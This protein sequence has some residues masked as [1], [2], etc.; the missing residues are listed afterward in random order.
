MKEVHGRQRI[1]DLTAL[2][3]K[4]LHGYLL[5]AL[6]V[7]LAVP[8]Y[9]SLTPFLLRKL[10]SD[11]YGLWVIGSIPLA[12]LN[13]S[14]FGLKNSLV[15]RAAR[16][17]D[18]EDVAGYF[19]AVFFF[20]L[21]IGLALVIALVSWGEGLV[22]DIFNIPSRYRHEGYL[23]VLLSTIGFGIRFL[24]TPYQALLESKQEFAVINLISLLWLIAN[25]VLSIIVL[26]ISPDL[27]T[28]VST[29]VALNAV[30][31]FLYAYFC[32]KSTKAARIR[33]RSIRRSHVR[34]L[35][36]Y[37]LG[38]Y[39][40]SLAILLREPMYKTLITRE[41]GLPATASFEI[42][43]RLCCQLMSFIT[44]PAYGIFA[45]AATLAGRDAE[46]TD[47]L[48]TIQ[49]AI[50]TLTVPMAL[51]FMIFGKL[52]IGLWLGAG[53]ES[54]VMLVPWF[55]LSFALYYLSEASAKAIEGLGHARASAIVQIAGVV[56]QL[57]VFFLLKDLGLIAASISLLAGF[58]LVSLS[59]GYVYARSV[60]EPRLFTGKT[61]L[62]C[63]VPAIGYVAAIVSL[64]DRNNLPLFLL[65]LVL[66][67]EFARIAGV[68]DYRQVVSR[69]VA[70]FVRKSVLRT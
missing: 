3:Q 30:V 25:Y 22:A 18:E 1:M 65:F 61:L 57:G 14:D 62:L 12:I 58:L 10:G 35:A 55:V 33:V 36:G 11:Y 38:I 21:V 45:T 13:I 26:S 15:Y 60:K 50:L 66:H 51:F 6:R 69:L 31:F 56:L 34:A 39:A 42:T 29:G 5:G 68:I 2:K 67:L 19:N 53:H 37:G 49:G 47:I 54:V 32:N 44:L 7:I 59:Y 43:Y 4:L 9:I 70:T 8:I 52:F 23:V 41:Y 28:L 16:A 64:N 48:R 40:A 17:V 20:F 63:L 24:A 46:L 27:F